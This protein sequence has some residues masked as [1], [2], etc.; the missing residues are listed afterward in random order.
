MRPLAYSN[1]STNAAPTINA[2]GINSP[3][4]WAFGFSIGAGYEFFHYDWDCLAKYSFFTT[5]ANSSASNTFNTTLKMTSPSK[6]SPLKSI[7]DIRKKEI[8]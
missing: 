1:N 5:T 3:M 8:L 4:N 6:G 7:L 2:S